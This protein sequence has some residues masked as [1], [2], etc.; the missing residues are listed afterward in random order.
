[1]FLLPP[2]C[3]GLV[4]SPSVPALA[5]HRAPIAAPCNPTSSS[6]V[7][8]GDSW[9]PLPSSLLATP[10][11]V[12]S[13]TL[14]P[15]ERAEA[16]T[17]GRLFLGLI[18]ANSIFWQYLLPTLRGEENAAT[19]LPFLKQKQKQKPKS[20][21]GGERLRMQLGDATPAQS[22]T[23]EG[24]SASGMHL[25]ALTLAASRRPSFQL[26][27]MHD[28]ECAVATLSDAAT[29]A[30]ELIRSPA[31]EAWPS[32]AAWP[33]LADVRVEVPIAT[34]DSRQHLKALIEAR[35]G[36]TPTFVRED[37]QRLVSLFATCAREAGGATR[38]T[39]LRVRLLVS[40][41]VAGAC[42]QLHYDNVALRLSCAYHGTGTR[43]LPESSLNRYAF[44]ALQRRSSLP[45]WLQTALTQPQGW[46]LYNTLV[47]WPWGAERFAPEGHA[48]LMKGSRW[49]RG[50]P[51]PPSLATAGAWRRRDR[52]TGYAREG[53]LRAWPALHRSPLVAAHDEGAESTRLSGRRVLFTVDYLG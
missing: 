16:K 27:P 38:N 50:Q 10:E 14:T 20:R 43:Y 18:V 33:N 49:R 40:D 36:F 39:T 47:R 51:R 6:N 22:P 30:V 28:P 12:D 3:S 1:M 46:A 17:R 32:A 25:P 52:N 53:V 31:A 34:A 26:I 41:G 2:L 13:D 5:V 44:I 8:L 45:S 29:S 42:T 24:A 15:A 21:G 35:Y 37:M 11:N 4:T 23:R 9:A 7:F 19:K 48:L